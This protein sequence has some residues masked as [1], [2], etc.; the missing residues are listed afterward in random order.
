MVSFSNGE[1]HHILISPVISP[2]I[3]PGPP[4]E[5][6]GGWGPTPPSVQTHHAMFNKGWRDFL[7]FQVPLRPATAPPDAFDFKYS[8]I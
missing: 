4:P 5:G 8:I 6:R 2:V 1:T 7:V 3:S